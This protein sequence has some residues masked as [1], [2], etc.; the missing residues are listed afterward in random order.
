MSDTMARSWPRCW[1]SGR[2]SKCQ[3]GEAPSLFVNTLGMERQVCVRHRAWDIEE[4]TAR[5]EV[6]G[7]CHLPLEVQD[8]VKADQ[9]VSRGSLNDP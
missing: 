4:Q 6:T 7:A 1:I 3:Q 2:Q 8:Q 9:E 5:L